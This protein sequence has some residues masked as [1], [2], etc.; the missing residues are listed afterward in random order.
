MVK[1]FPDLE[2]F[3][4]EVVLATLAK[5]ARRL[6]HFS[7]LAIESVVNK[8]SGATR[9]IFYVLMPW[10]GLSLDKQLKAD[11]SLG[12][13][14]TVSVAA[15]LYAHLHVIIDT[16]DLFAQLHDEEIMGKGVMYADVKKENLAV[17]Q[18]DIEGPGG[19]Y[20]RCTVIDLGGLV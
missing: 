3:L 14:E 1:A 20:L 12:K 11:R 5:S 17:A 18:T 2:E 6:V 13:Y 15:V 9:Q 10:C 19:G 7:R 8:D 4:T 16:L